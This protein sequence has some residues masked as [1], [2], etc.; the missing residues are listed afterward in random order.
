MMNSPSA[1]RRIR[2]SL[3]V[4]LL[5]ALAASDV[6]TAFA[7][8]A[9]PAATPATSVGIAQPA[10]AASAP[11]GPVYGDL[12][13]LTFT[14][15]K[16]LVASFVSPG[17]GFASD[18]IAP[19]FV[20]S[21]V[22][23]AGVELSVND[24]IVPFSK[25]GKRTVADKTGETQ[26]YYYGVGLDE[27]PNTAT[28]TALGADGLRG[29]S[30]SETIFGPGH[31]VRIN[32][33]IVGNAVADGKTP[34]IFRVQG[35]D[36]YGHHAAPGA[37]VK[38]AIVR[39]DAHFLALRDRAS[40]ALANGA[41]APGAVASAV[42]AVGIAVPQSQSTPFPF[43]STAP[44]SVPSGGPQQG[45][46]ANPHA[47][48]DLAVPVQSIEVPLGDGGIAEMNL[49]PGLQPGEIRV[50]ASIADVSTEAQSYVAPYLRKAMVLGLATTGVGSVPGV[51]GE[52]VTEAN[53]V[54][55][56]R[57]RIAIYGV[58]Q[59]TKTAQAQVAYDTADVLQNTSQYGSFTDNP[60]ETPY[61]T[62]G[63]SS[64]RRD[65]A[66][67]NDH[68]Y[69]RID[70]NRS[71]VMWGEF[72][73]NTAGSTG[74]GFQ[75]LVDGAKVEIAGN[76]AKLTAFNSHNDVAYARQIFSP[77]GLA[78][79]GAL[80]HPDIVVGSDTVTLVALDRRTG[81][82]LT[83]TVL[84][85]N[86][87]YTIDYGTGQ[88]RFINPPLPFDLNF[89]PQQLLVQ[90][91]YSGAGVS[92]QTTGGRFEAGIGGSQA[93]RFGAGYV[94]DSTG[95]GNYALL[96][97]D[98]TGKLSGGSWTFAHEN[99]QGS[100]ADL[101]STGGNTG[102]VLGGSQTQGNAYRATLTQVAG[103]NHLSLNFDS[104][105]AGYDN[106]FGGISTAGLLDYRVEYQRLLSKASDS[107]TVSFDHEQ[108]NLATGINSS[109]NASVLAQQH[110]TK[111][112]T[113]RAGVNVLT[114][115]GT[116]VSN[117][118][119]LA[120]QI[121]T[122]PTAAPIPV[123]SAPPTPGLSTTTTQVD[124]GAEY[125][126]APTVDVSL[127]RITSL[128][129]PNQA[130]QPSQTTAQIS[131]DT[132]DHG[133][134]YVRQLWAGAPVQSFAASTTSLTTAS[135][136]TRS[137]AVGLEQSVGNNTTVDSEYAVEDTGNGSDVYSSIGGHEKFFLG[138]NL[139]GDFQLQ[140]AASVGANGGAFDL[141]G[142]TLAYAV[143]TRFR[144]TTDYQLRTGNSSGYTLNVGAAGALS[145]N[146]SMFV[147]SNNSTTAGYSNVDDQISL[148]YRPSLNDRA[149]TLFGYQA[150][151]GN[152]STL[153]DHTQL[154]SLEELYRPDRLLEI[155]GRYAYKLDGD[156]YYPAR[157][158]L[159]GIRVTQR[160]GHR[161]DVAAESRFLSAHDV[162][163]A[164]TTGF[165]VEAGYRVGG[166]MRVAAGYNFTGSPDPSL[167]LA[168]TRRGV[169][170]TATS[171]IDRI[172]GWGKDDDL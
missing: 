149:V 123:V 87:D 81:A 64:Q 131:V 73:A 129:G 128:S 94:N 44:D 23:G 26:Y 50:R 82:V 70:S 33:S 97:E 143:G 32:G 138:K 145:D 15:T 11:A 9:P 98:I 10:P 136:S 161:F 85:R 77:T 63:D 159:F 59:I 110:V 80:L 160:L 154:L 84:G 162:P 31:A 57:G 49:I 34:V 105:S 155:A 102:N 60:Q 164:S 40:A 165:A 126:V 22:E 17:N 68:L 137:T 46:V 101:G 89:N 29:T 107:V 65:D 151:D 74:D 20:V 108:N 125:K 66:L 56:R 16:N 41:T 118:S 142:L 111:R 167:A 135:S 168:P 158:S 157:S 58:G 112:V 2:A 53:G 127:D 146:V 163:G 156:A 114:S 78:T 25:I 113:V 37:T 150:I 147:T 45:E 121:N 144:A 103:P 171:V 133:K 86:I 120:S 18:S 67:S 75:Q 43:S 139:H 119:A 38:L 122:V 76:N 104:T 35:F 52:A 132:P 148:A 27:G 13:H 55:A 117:D 4:S 109:S 79:I 170:A 1:R 61:L 36:R 172:F 169:Y 124:V 83:Q 6:D 99:S 88:I 90:Y 95:S 166:E 39:G 100:L 7:D 140:H 8:V 69:A 153:G 30:V 116:T 62:Y 51:P 141:Y 152:V 14:A 28:I 19:T 134:A 12:T 72:Q 24:K 47:V 71:N 48:G 5:F 115:N 42:P 54:N 3:A 21:T 96:G 106:P 91:E 130:S 92:A 93:V